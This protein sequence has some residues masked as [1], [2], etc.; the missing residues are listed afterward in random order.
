MHWNYQTFN[1]ING[2]DLYEMLKL[3][4]DVFIVEQNCSYSELDDYD[5]DSIHIS[6]RDESG[7]IAYARLL[8]AGVKYDE[9]SIGRVI[10]R[11]D[12]RG[13]GLA[14]KLMEN[15]KEYMIENWAPHKIRLQAQC[16]LEKFYGAHGFDAISE[17]YMDDQIPHIDMILQLKGQ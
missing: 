6:C 1:D 5:Q 11:A 9:A 16:H 13:T 14:H 3:R 17:P 15:C 10:I 7:I 8:P 12:K 2:N 4:V